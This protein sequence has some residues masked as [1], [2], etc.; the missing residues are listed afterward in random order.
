MFFFPQ[1]FFFKFWLNRSKTMINTYPRYCR[2]HSYRRIKTCHMLHKYT[3][4]VTIPCPQIVDGW[5]NTQ[6]QD[7]TALT[8]K[9]YTQEFKKVLKQCPQQEKSLSFWLKYMHML[10][11]IMVYAL[12]YTAKVDLKKSPILRNKL[13]FS[14]KVSISLLIKCFKGILNE[15]WWKSPVSII[16][17]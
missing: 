14:R 11:V 5:T 1:L 9:N 17:K 6:R 8:H 7:K 2:G 12:W 16:A 4:M 3:N 13:F 10:N 15:A